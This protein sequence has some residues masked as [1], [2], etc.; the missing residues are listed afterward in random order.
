VDFDLSE[1]QTMLVDTV[2]QIA[3][4]CFGHAVAR[5]YTGGARTVAAKGWSTLVESGLT[6]LLLPADAGGAGA[7][8]LD[9][10]LVLSELSAALAPVPYLSSAVAVPLLVRGF[11]G[12]VADL[13]A[14]EILDGRVFGLVVGDDLRLPSSSTGLR[15]IGWAD[16]RP[17]VGIDQGGL[18]L[19]DAIRPGRNI[20]LLDNMGLVSADIVLHP[21]AHWETDDG[22][23]ALAGIRTAIA[24]GLA[25][26]VDGCAQLAWEHIRQRRQYGQPIGTFQVVRHMAADLLVDVDTCR[27][28]TYGAAWSVDNADAE[29]GERL[30]KI[31]KAWCSQAAV[32]SAETAMQLLGGIGVTWES[33]A[34]LYLRR[35]QVWSALLG[36]VTAMAVDLGSDF[37]SATGVS[38]R[39]S[40]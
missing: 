36:G 37:I 16:G 14:Q 34:H 17:G 3:G 9:A 33:A 21:G 18:T 5:D 6:A 4:Q 20:D 10:C 27:S 13:I 8:V 32:R 38:H 24:S 23:R 15:C 28:I 26:I 31:A 1:E 7:G 25:G 22:R 19:I 12:E 39:G 30:S 29:S 2:R 35:A 40:A 11:R